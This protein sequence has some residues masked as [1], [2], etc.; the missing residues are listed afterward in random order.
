MECEKNRNDFLHNNAFKKIINLKKD[1]AEKFSKTTG[2][3]NTKSTL[4]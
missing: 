4:G 1:Y 3:K 2:I